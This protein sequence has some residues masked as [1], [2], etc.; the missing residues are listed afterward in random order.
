MSHFLFRN[1]KAG[2]VTYFPLLVLPLKGPLT[3]LQ[4]KEAIGF[5]KAAL[6]CTGGVPSGS[7]GGTVT[8]PPF[9]SVATP[10]RE[11]IRNTKQK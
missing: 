8:D 3:Y 9:S 5:D 6:S 2:G 11:A 10:I 7:H 4:T 1:S